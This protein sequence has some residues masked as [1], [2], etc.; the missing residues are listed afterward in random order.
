MILG[1]FIISGSLWVLLALVNLSFLYYQTIPLEE[2]A[3]EKSLPGYKKYKA[4]TGA[5]LPKLKRDIRYNSL[6]FK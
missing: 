1:Y 4:R 6:I 3:L 5:V 2:N